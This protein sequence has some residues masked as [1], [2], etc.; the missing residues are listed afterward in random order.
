[1]L[2]AETEQRP[3]TRQIGIVCLRIVWWVMKRSS[4][5]AVSTWLRQKPA[6]MLI[7]NGSVLNRRAMAMV[8]KM[9]RG[10]N[11]APT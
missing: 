6:Q 10:A 2:S 7:M 4:N 3:Q 8:I 11:M 9:L 5:N 1:M